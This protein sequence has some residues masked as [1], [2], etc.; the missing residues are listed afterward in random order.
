M[1]EF[2][3]FCWQTWVNGGIMMIPL[4]ILAFAIFFSIL[5]MIMDLHYKIGKK[6]GKAMRKEVLGHAHDVEELHWDFIHKEALE[7]GYF[8][9]W[10]GLTNKLVAAAPLVGLLGTVTGMI[11]LFANMGNAGDIAQSLSSGISKALYPPA[12][13]LVIAMFGMFGL[14]FVK[15]KLANYDHFFLKM[16]RKATKKYLKNHDTHRKSEEGAGD[17]PLPSEQN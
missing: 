14:S 8:H 17:Y 1:T 7:M 3:S 10:M 2:I 4:A 15:G 9:R 12:L 6:V 11:Y 13:G 16:E 5:G